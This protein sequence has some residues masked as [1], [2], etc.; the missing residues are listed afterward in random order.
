MTDVLK[1]EAVLFAFGRRVSEQELCRML[2]VSEQKL[3]SLLKELEQ[4]YSSGSIALDNEG[5]FWKLSVK[6]E[7][8]DLVK[9]IVT[10]TELDRPTLETLAVIAFKYPVVQSDV[11]KVRNVVAYDHIKTL[12]E[13]GYVHRE[14]YRHTFR[15]KLTPKFFEY[16]DLPKEKLKEYFK[17][18]KDLAST[19]EQKKDKELANFTQNAPA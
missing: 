2:N 10:K 3:K 17:E 11:V 12:M 7:Y 19:M 13:L 4:K 8:L 9:S 14:K 6:D 16:F 15:L 1:L 18:Y 5:A